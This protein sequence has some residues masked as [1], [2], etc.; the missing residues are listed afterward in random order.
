MCADRG[1]DATI[2]GK[3]MDGRLIDF[4]ETPGVIQGPPPLLGQH[5]ADILRELGYAEAEIAGLAA[6]GVVHIGGIPGLSGE[7]GSER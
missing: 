3:E 7:G 5:T 1:D 2:H 4:S 6:N